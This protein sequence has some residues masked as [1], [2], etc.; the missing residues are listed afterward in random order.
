MGFKITKF[1][2]VKAED[3]DF[4]AAPLFR[5]I[6]ILP[7]QNVK[8]ATHDEL[9]VTKQLDSSGHLFEESARLAHAGD[10]II[11]RAQDDRYPLS[12]DDFQKFYEED[13]LNP[14]QFRSKNYGHAIQVTQ[15]V[16]IQA[17]WGED[18]KIKAGGVIYKM[19]DGRIS[20][21]QKH[22]FEADFARQGMD[23]SLMPLSAPLEEQRD[24]AFEKG[25]IAHLR[26]IDS[27]MQQETL[28]K[29]RRSITVTRTI[30]NGPEVL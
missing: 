30:K 14:K 10:E 11:T 24:W 18:Q 5:K 4:N 13:P 17:H 26:D 8:I 28:S 22:S 27:R 2:R 16:I 9:V 3:F 21:N 25:E 7:K 20:G 29:K 1:K 23:G 6:A 19:F 12:A 15:D